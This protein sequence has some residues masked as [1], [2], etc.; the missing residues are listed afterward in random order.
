[1]VRLSRGTSFRLIFGYIAVFG[2]VSDT[3]YHCDTSPKGSC[4][5]RN[6]LYGSA[7]LLHPKM[8]LRKRRFIRRVEIRAA[9]QSRIP[10]RLQGQTA[11]IN[12][13]DLFAASSA[14]VDVKCV[15]NIVC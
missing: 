2:M 12:D 3:S 15:L 6:L 7:V 1:M 10:I 5:A 13:N 4:P 11:T 9:T 8:L 14:L